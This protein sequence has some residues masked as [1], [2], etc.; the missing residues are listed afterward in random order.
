VPVALSLS[1]SSEDF[2]LKYFVGAQLM[3]IF[4]TNETGML[5]F[6]STCRHLGTLEPG[7]QLKVLNLLV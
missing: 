7:V 4:G 5:A 1:K 2:L 3:G 6:S